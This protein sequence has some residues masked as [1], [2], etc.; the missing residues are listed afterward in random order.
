MLEVCPTIALSKPSVEVHPLSI[1]GKED[2]ARLVFKT[3]PGNAINV[4]VIDLGNR[5]RMI[6]ND[7][8]VVK[9]PDMPKLPVASVLWKPLPD[10]KR[11][12]AAWILSGGAHHTGFSTAINSEY[13]ED[14]A[15]M[16]GIEYILIDEKCDLTSLKNELRWNEISY[17]ISGGIN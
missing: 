2:P 15:G 1:G 10:L 8:E 12:A 14:F 3:A 4:S 9:C 17:H 7:V 5:F 11:G 16:M 13:L 6:V